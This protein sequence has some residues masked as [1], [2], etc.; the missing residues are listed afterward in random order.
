[1]NRA[2]EPVPSAQLALAHP[3]VL[4]HPAIDTTAPE[5]VMLRI[6]WF[7]SSTKKI[8][9]GLPK[10]SGPAVVTPR[11]LLSLADVPVPSWSPEL[12]GAPASVETA[13]STNEILRIVWLEPSDTY[14]K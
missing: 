10:D 13:A 12:P 7:P 9:P 8:V 3:M 5:G 2:E 6:L 14:A 11:G 1:M 4:E